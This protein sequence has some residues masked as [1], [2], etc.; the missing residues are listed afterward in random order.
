MHWI[1]SGSF[2]CTRRPCPKFFSDAVANNRV[3][4]IE[5]AKASVEDVSCTLM[6]EKSQ[7][8]CTYVVKWLSSSY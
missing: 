1:H 5:H 3:Y 2:N 6:K 4:G 7:K 8:V